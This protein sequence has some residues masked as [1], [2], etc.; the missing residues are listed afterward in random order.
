M[1]FTADKVLSNVPELIPYEQE[2]QR[3]VVY[4]NRK[5]W[6]HGKGRIITPDACELVLTTKV[7][8]FQNETGKDVTLEYLIKNAINYTSLEQA[9]EYLE[10]V[11][12]WIKENTCKKHSLLVF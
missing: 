10:K 6:L 9:S 3:I 5:M 1:S 2:E 7:R 8:I 12:Q 4:T 11:V